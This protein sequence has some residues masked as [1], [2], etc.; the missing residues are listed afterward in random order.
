[1]VL[2]SGGHTKEMITLTQELDRS[3]YAPAYFVRASV[4]PALIT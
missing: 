1:V 4:R 3:R 2:G